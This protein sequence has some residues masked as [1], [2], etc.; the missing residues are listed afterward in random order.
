[1]PDRSRPVRSCRYL[2]T[3]LFIPINGDYSNNSNN[4]MAA[5][6]QIEMSELPRVWLEMTLRNY[7]KL[8]V[9]G[10]S[11]FKFNEDGQAFLCSVLARVPTP[12]SSKE[13]YFCDIL[14]HIPS[15]IGLQD[16]LVSYEIDPDKHDGLTNAR[17]EMIDLLAT[18]R[19]A[20]Q[21][22]NLMDRTYVDYLSRADFRASDQVVVMTNFVKYRAGKKVDP[23]EVIK[24]PTDCTELARRV[25]SMPSKKR[26]GFVRPTHAA[27]VCASC[28][29]KNTGKAMF[30]R[31]SRCKLSLYC[32][33]E[34]QVD[35]WDMHKHI[36]K[37][38]AAQTGGKK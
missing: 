5:N 17:K 14:Y 20:H 35:H 22:F 33:Q 18:D 4:D 23:V 26:G 8:C 36:C 25:W 37:E 1:M 10:V 21:V 30:K 9:L 2:R 38:I 12:E 28:L 34:C 7:G 31:C 32:G 15:C 11:A 13:E 3:G 24:R 29:Q 6:V 19:N 16:G 27:Q